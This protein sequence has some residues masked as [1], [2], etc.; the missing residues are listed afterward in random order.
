MN[1][2]KKRVLE[3]LHVMDASPKKSLGQNFLI[4]DNVINK[5]IQAV[6]KRKPKN[7]I[8]VGP[9]LGALT[10]H[11][12]AL[13]K[14][15]TLIELDD[16]FSAYWQKQSEFPSSSNLDVIVEDALRLNW[17]ELVERET[18]LVSNLPYQIS[19]SLV[20]DRSFGPSFIDQMVLMFQ[21]EV[22]E[23]ITSDVSKKSFG[24]LTVISQV[25]WEV[26][27]VCDAGPGSFYPAPKVSSRVL[28]FKRK[29]L[30]GELEIFND[31]KVAQS[32]LK[33]VKAAFLHRR[34][35]L[36]KNLKPVMN[37][38]KSL[39]DVEDVFNSMDINLK[40]RAEEV[41]PME[42][43]ELFKSISLV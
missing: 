40:A 11:L 12:V 5:I 23:R 6:V 27:L 21:K 28:Y 26:G 16:E 15:L 41:Y 4:D 25:F 43:V 32:F 37:E 33:F 2:L 22:A 30:Q 7:L 42:Y 35:F 9:G 1:D 31:A 24:L 14:P 17:Q 38:N 20:M 29:S 39:S 13:E 34:K 3:Q 19:S 8:E 36:L 18:L 10:R